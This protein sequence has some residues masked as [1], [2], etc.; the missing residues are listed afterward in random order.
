MTI[1]RRLD[2]TFIER[3]KVS[4]P[5]LYQFLKEI[6]TLTDSIQND[7]APLTAARSYA[8][9]PDTILDVTNFSYS[10]NSSV[11]VNFTWDA[12][13]GAVQYEIRQ[14]ITFDLGVQIVVTSVNSAVIEPPETGVQLSYW[15]VAVTSGGTIS[16]NPTNLQFS[17]DPPGYVNISSRIID[18]NVLLWWTLPQTTFDIDYY[19]VYKDTTLVGRIAGNFTTIFEAISGTYVYGIEPV[20]IGGNVGVKSTVEL[21]VNPPPDYELLDSFYSDLS[22]VKTNCILIFE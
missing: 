18:N 6:K 21:F 9:S 14:G 1:K 7:L 13:A 3:Y 2:A 19:N 10:V 12:V 15:I 17:L 16:A 20:D 4:D 11:G 22:G 5:A 8:A